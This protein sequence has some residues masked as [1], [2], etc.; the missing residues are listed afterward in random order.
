MPELFKNKNK[1]KNIYDTGISKQKNLV[2]SVSAPAPTEN[3]KVFGRESLSVPVPKLAKEKSLTGTVKGFFGVKRDDRILPVGDNDQ[4]PQVQVNAGPLRTPLIDLTDEERK[5]YSDKQREAKWAEYTKWTD[6]VLKSEEFDTY[7]DG[8]KSMIRDLNRLSKEGN[9]LDRSMLID[10]I[11]ESI[12][13]RNADLLTEMGEAELLADP[14]EKEQKIQAIYSKYPD[15][16]IRM[17][18]YTMIRNNATGNLEVDP[19]ARILDK[20]NDSFFVKSEKLSKPLRGVNG[21]SFN[22]EVV[23]FNGPEA[24][25]TRKNLFSN[26]PS[27][28]DIVQGELADC[29]FLSTIGG[30][31]EKDPGI[32]KNMMKDEGATVLVRFYSMKTEQPVYVRVKKTIPLVRYTGKDANGQP[33]ST[34][35]SIYGNKGAMWVNILEKAMS[36]VRLDI[37]SE[38]PEALANTTLNTYDAISSFDIEKAFFML[39]GKKL[40]RHL[41]PSY[42]GEKKYVEI[43]SLFEQ[44]H[45]GEKETYLKGKKQG[46]AHRTASDWNRYKAEKIFGIH[47]EQGN[48]EVEN[49]FKGKRVFEA[50]ENFMKNH[51][52]TNFESKARPK[53]TVKGKD[54]F[55]A[56]F[57]NM[58]DLNLFLDSIDTSKMPVLGLGHGIDEE[59][60]KKNYIEYFRSSISAS[61]LL[62]IGINIDGKYNENEKKIWKELNNSLIDKDGNRKTVVAGTNILNL[63]KR[64]GAALKGNSGEIITGG[65]AATHAYTIMGTTIKDVVIKGKTVKQRFVIIKN[66][67]NNFKIRLYDKDTMRPYMNTAENKEDGSEYQVKGTF[68]MEF[69]DFCETFCYYSTEEKTEADAVAEEE[70]VKIADIRKSYE[71]A[72]E[73]T[74]EQLNTK[75]FGL[76]NDALSQLV[77]IVNGYKNSP[78]YANYQEDT[79]LLIEKLG[80]IGSPEY[81]DATR[82]QLFAEIYPVLRDIK[83]EF[84]TIAS[85]IGDELKAQLRKDLK[86]KNKDADVIYELAN[87]LLP[88]TTGNLQIPPEDEI[89]K[90]TDDSQFISTKDFKE[91]V[92]TTEG[93]IIHREEVFFD[94]ARSNKINEPLFWAE[95]STEDIAQGNIGDCYML[96]GLNA[97]M[98]REPFAIKNAMKD[99]G[100][101]VVVR[102]YNYETGK[103]V[104]VRVKKTVALSRYTGTYN[105][106]PFTSEVV[107]GSRRALWVNILEKAMAVARDKLSDPQYEKKER[108]HGFDAVS[109][110]RAESF[111]RIFTGKKVDIK[112]LYGAA[113]KYK[114]YVGLDELKNSVHYNEKDAFLRGRNEDGSARTTEDWN[115]YKAKKM[116]GIDILPKQTALYEM[117]KNNTILKAYEDFLK[118]HLKE[119]FESPEYDKGKKVG[120]VT[121]NDLDLFLD[122]ID[123]KKMPTFGLSSGIDEDELKKNYIEYFRKSATASNL[124]KNNVCMDG[125]YS[126]FE[127]DVYQKIQTALD[128]TQGGSK[129]VIAAVNG[130]SLKLKTKDK[131]KESG[132]TIQFGIGLDHAYSIHGVS[133]IKTMYNGREITRYF[134]EVRNPWNENIVR[135]YDKDTMKS[136]MKKSD[137]NNGAG[138]NDSKGTFLMELRDFCETFARYGIEE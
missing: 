134:I 114:Q 105:G 11:T 78:D 19:N 103:P 124:L 75:S 132:E 88:A 59:Q 16:K 129:M 17:S 110:G 138:T 106:E 109:S 130:S 126:D 86:E 137:A 27:V 133:G 97:I 131:V 120:F 10:T 111:I 43:K 37:D 7:V 53:G 52:K 14:V 31:L 48:R 55:K 58:T 13:V 95:P 100:A 71:P 3:T 85:V 128:D 5:G 107:K 77:T 102:F 18:L 62:G 47:I 80:L 117:F 115:R 41:L 70:P 64:E 56:A 79:K 84:K 23:D 89:I 8:T 15:A 38:L 25:Y 9:S 98:E 36:A 76:R 94:E 87:M 65:V 21:K 96:S 33:A 99:E 40:E 135:H 66:P 81:T 136:F 35:A 127:K 116:F 91:Y 69:T 125:Q 1:Q 118:K 90:G 82:T 39:T 50:Y 49:I 4:N 93:K 67:W 123:I 29:G 44:V 92:K 72:V 42:T 60:M 32:I 26:E 68:L 121:T 22:K 108:R 24:D 113:N 63:Q 2:S 45:Y 101:S 28:S 57:R 51:L 30:I 104:Y 54:P 12:K 46:G 34:R 112:Y 61:G 6:D 83:E 122:S 20:S 73:L 74:E 119:D